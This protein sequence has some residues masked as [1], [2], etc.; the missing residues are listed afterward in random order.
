MSNPDDEWAAAE[1]ETSGGVGRALA[2]SAPSYSVPKPATPTFGDGLEAAVGIGRAES[3]PADEAPA[4]TGV[5]A[6]QTAPTLLLLA[7][8]AAVL[9]GAIV[10]PVVGG[11]TGGSAAW[12]LAGPVAILLVGG[13]LIVDGRRRRS[14]WYRPQDIAQWLLRAVIIASVLVVA[15]SSFLIAN[16]ISRGRWS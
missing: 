4:T 12:I 13:F 6:V 2:G 16:D 7:A 10:A 15:F 8:L 5:S 14:G 11:G 1:A 3:T 9:I